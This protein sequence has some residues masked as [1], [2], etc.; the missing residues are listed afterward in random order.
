MSG[1][2]HAPVIPS[3]ATSKACAT[4]EKIPSADRLNGCGDR[5]L[6]FQTIYSASLRALETDPYQEVAFAVATSKAACE[7]LGFDSEITASR[8]HLYLWNE[9]L[10]R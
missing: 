10:V 3:P 4:D 6:V 7:N 5:H 9:T 8:M 2:N 1:L